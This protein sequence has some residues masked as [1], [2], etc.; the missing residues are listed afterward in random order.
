MVGTSFLQK[1]EIVRI[2]LSPVFYFEV[3]YLFCH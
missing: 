3:S 2:A 1:I